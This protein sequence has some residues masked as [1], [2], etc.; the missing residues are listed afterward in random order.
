LNRSDIAI[1][2]WKNPEIRKKRIEAL[3]EAHRSEKGRKNH[4][5]ALK[6]YFSDPE[7]L[8]ERKQALKETWAKPEN[9]VKIIEIAKMGSIAALSPKGRRNLNRAN[10][11]PEL[12]KSRSLVAKKYVHKRMLNKDKYSKL[13]KFLEEKMNSIGLFP[14]REYP[15]GPYAVDFCFVDEK[16]VIEAD[17]DFWH[18]NPEFLKEKGR[19]ELYSMQ[20]RT[21]TLD[22]AKNTYLK[23]HGWKLLRFWERDIKSN[24]EECLRK[25][26]AS[27][28]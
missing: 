19:T 14:V 10:Q 3:Q 28:K 1:L 26:Q 17:G 15:L 4:S 11:N 2:S 20:K 13:N 22:K 25:I 12:R 16:L 27:L 5:R 18:A 23:N 6:K 7:N 8:K 9:K 21:I 24:P